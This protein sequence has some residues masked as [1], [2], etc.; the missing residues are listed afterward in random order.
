MSLC[1]YVSVDLTLPAVP[2]IRCLIFFYM[3]NFPVAGT[4]LDIYLSQLHFGY[5]SSGN[6]LS[7]MADYYVSGR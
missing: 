5:T 4:G 2:S 3:Y 6:V 7:I 1:V